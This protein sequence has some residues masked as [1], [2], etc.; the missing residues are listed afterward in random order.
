M[1]LPRGDRYSWNKKGSAKLKERRRV[2][3]NMLSDLSKN[4]WRHA[5]PC[6][7]VP[8]EKELTEIEHKLN[9]TETKHMRT[10]ETLKNPSWN[11]KADIIAAADNFLVRT[12]A[13]FNPSLPPKD[14]YFKTLAEAQTHA[15]VVLGL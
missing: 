12:D 7:Y 1:K 13:I 14:F 2:I 8:L 4:S 15:K 9:M 10:L 5:L 6:D 3:I 11:M